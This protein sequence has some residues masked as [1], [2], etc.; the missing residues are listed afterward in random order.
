MKLRATQQLQKYFWELHYLRRHLTWERK[1]V[2]NSFSTLECGQEPGHIDA[3]IYRNMF[4]DKATLKRIVVWPSL[5][6]RRLTRSGALAA[7]FQANERRLF[8][9]GQFW[10]QPSLY[11]P[12]TACCSFLPNV[13]LKPKSCPCIHLVCVNSFGPFNARETEPQR[14][15]CANTLLV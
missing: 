4:N 1:H 9:P 5:S 11:K 6:P 3:S 15:S 10:R 12:I 2:S 7:M 14:A 8:A 13:Y